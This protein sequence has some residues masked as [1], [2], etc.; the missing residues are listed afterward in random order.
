MQETGVDICLDVHGDEGL[1]YNFI[2]SSEGIPSWTP[3]RQALLDR[4]KTELTL[5]NP[6]FQTEH[7]YP[8]A[9]PGR[10]NLSMCSNYVAETFGCLAMTLEMPFKDTV[11]T[12]NTMQGWSPERSEHLG[13]ANV[14]AIY[15]VMDG[16]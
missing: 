10:A 2:A 15:R 16:L 12:P 11:D 14:E 3:E 8:V 13:A 5:A 9:P 1:P 7:G 6:D 4:Y